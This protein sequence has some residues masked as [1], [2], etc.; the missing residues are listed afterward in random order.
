M[1]QRSLYFLLIVCHGI[2]IYGQTVDADTLKTVTKEVQLPYSIQKIEP[3]IIKEVRGDNVGDILKSMT[4][5]FIKAVGPGGIASI[6]MRGGSAWQTQVFW[7]GIAINSPTLGQSDL[8]L[9]PF[10]FYSGIEVYN[11]GASSRV[12][13]GGIAGSI[14]LNSSN[15]SSYGGNVHFEKEFGSFG[16]DHTTAKLRLAKDSKLFSETVLFKK[17]ADNNFN[18]LDY[19][20]MDHLI[21]ERKNSAF[22]QL[23]GQQNLQIRLKKEWLKL[24]TS[25]VETDRNIPAAIGVQ[26][27]LQTQKD[28][29]YKALIQYKTT[30]AVH[31]YGA[32]HRDF[33]HIATLGLIHDYQNYQSPNALINAQYF[34]TTYS[35]QFHSTYELKKKVVLKTQINEYLYRAISDGFNH[36]IFQNRLSISGIGSKTWNSGNLNLSVQELL[37]NTEL[38]LPIC[39]LGGYVLF[40]LLGKTQS[41]Y[42]NVGTNYR[43]P[44]LNDLYWSVGGNEH[45]QPESSFNYELGIKTFDSN[46]KNKIK[47]DLVYFQDYVDNWIQWIPDFSGIWKPQ[48]VKSVNKQGIDVSL[49][50]KKRIKYL[51]YVFISSN[52]R[53]V[54][55]K[56]IRTEFA[57]DQ[58]G[59]ELIYTPRHIV[60]IY[61]ALKLLRFTF[62]YNQTF[63]SKF[64]LDS[65]NTTYLPYSAPA[66]FSIKYRFDEEEDANSNHLSV[67]LTLHNIWGED[68]QVVANQPMPGRWFSIKLTYN[69][70]NRDFGKPVN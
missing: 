5:N 41:V 43:Y 61:A 31:E 37:I 65:D 17:V 10:E 7:E 33:I 64:Y 67:D 69:L 3:L 48:N 14:A 8:S 35:A 46:Y 62:R 63:T 49:E 39:N 13:Q 53:W 44:S 25:F 60:N 28:Q 4:P 52:Y 40:D 6:S 1:I 68:Y 24:I 55:A 59:K 56:V 34:N 18:Y 21:L 47:Y 19:S 2:A 38:S 23:G 42:G 22:S 27:Q 51:Q 9:L 32:D 12:G 54:N 26:D 50:Y 57:T 30:K 16:L 45:L 29:N 66:D 20:N 58:I 36:E 15:R 70:H 11:T